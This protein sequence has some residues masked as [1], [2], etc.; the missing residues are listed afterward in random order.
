MKS[1][2]LLSLAYTFVD[3]IHKATSDSN[4]QKSRKEKIWYDYVEQNRKWLK[5]TQMA[6]DGVAPIIG[7]RKFK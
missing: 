1:I 3:L 4:Q 2:L 6:S 7:W 5:T